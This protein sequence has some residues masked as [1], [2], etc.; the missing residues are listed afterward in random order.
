LIAGGIGITYIRALALQLADERA[1]GR[2]LERLQVLWSVRDQALVDRIGPDLFESVG[3]RNDYGMNQPLTKR[4]NSLV[5]IHLTGLS[6]P[7]PQVSGSNGEVDEFIVGSSGTQPGRPDLDAYFRGMIEVELKKLT[8]MAKP[9]QE[10][11]SPNPLQL[12]R[13]AVVVCGPNELIRET[14]QLCNCQSFGLF[15]IHIESFS[16]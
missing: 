2:P 11:C 6:S 7:E 12:S 5:N 8:A 13:V 10:E 4:S 1:R 9:T 3:L 16:M 14:A 15:D